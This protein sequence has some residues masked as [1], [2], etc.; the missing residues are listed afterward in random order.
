[1]SRSFQSLLLSTLIAISCWLG[2]GSLSFAQGL[3]TPTPAVLPGL[4]GLFAGE[5]PTNLGVKN[6]HLAPC[7]KTPNCVVSQAADADHAIAPI[8]YQADPAIAMASLIAVIES[9]PRSRIIKQSDNYLYAEFTS[10]LMGFVDDVEFYF[11]PTDQV[12]QVRSAARLGES[13]LSVNRKRVEAIR[14]E[15]QTG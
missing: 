8:N 9:M 1:M 10:R 6:G 11:D 12:I 5:P 3:Q 4:T 7:P 13:D 2:T 14:S 15:L